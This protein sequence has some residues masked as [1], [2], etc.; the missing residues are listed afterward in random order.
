MA[1]VTSLPPPESATSTLSLTEEKS[2]R[3]IR[4]LSHQQLVLMRFRKNRLAVLGLVVL[5]I[6]YIQAIF[7]EFLSPYDANRRFQGNVHI[8]PSVIHLR[9]TDGQWQRPFIY[10]VER[11]TDP[12]T[13]ERTYA[14]DTSK[15]FPIK[16]FV[17]GDPYV[18]WGL[19]QSD[20]HLFG[21]DKE[22]EPIAM[23]G[24][25]A[26]GRDLLSRIFYGGRISL[27]IP[28]VGVL[29]SLLIGLTLGGVSG[30]YGGV[31]DNIVQRLIELIRSIPTIP[32]WMGL[33]AALPPNWPQLRVYIAITIIL[34]FV[35]WTT[36]ARV[37]R[38]KFLALREEDFVLAALQAGARA[39]FVIREHLIPSFASYI[40]VYLTLAIPGLIIGETSLSFLGLGLVPPTISWGVLLKDAQK[41]AEVA[42]HP[43]I[44]SPALFVLATVMAFN[45]L[46]DGLRD[47]A[48]PYSQRT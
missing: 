42:L 3:S 35:G 7:C 27:S 6:L 28:L 43:W 36:L 19:I 48:D 30:Y 14:E 4:L 26:M 38:G 47:A 15:P 21:V 17:R 18:M 45:F 34:S 40:L 12:K 1:Q 25:D 9:T 10:K 16:F 32:L 46:G 11:T 20:L 31:V 2:T 22:A 39:G 29:L 13:F 41:V 23:L 8:P 44:L 24:G 5:V 33:A 37:I